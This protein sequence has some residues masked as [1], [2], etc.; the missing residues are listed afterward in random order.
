MEFTRFLID[1]YNCNSPVGK[2]GLERSDAFIEAIIG[3]IFLEKDCVESQ[4]HFS[5]RDFCF[6]LIDNRV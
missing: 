6:W 2:I 5:S 1:N 4:R 3:A